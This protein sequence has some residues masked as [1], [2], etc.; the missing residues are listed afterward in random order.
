MKN[1]SMGFNALIYSIERSNLSIHIERS[2]DWS[3]PMRRLYDV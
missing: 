1:I 2:M 3:I